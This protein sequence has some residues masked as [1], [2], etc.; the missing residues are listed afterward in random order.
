MAVGSPRLCCY[1]HLGEYL[2]SSSTPTPKTCLILIWRPNPGG[3]GLL[4]VSPDTD[5]ELGMS[6]S[7]MNPLPWMILFPNSSVF[8]TLLFLSP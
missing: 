3:T 4:G 5:W 1:C 2:H 6:D 7:S 8:L